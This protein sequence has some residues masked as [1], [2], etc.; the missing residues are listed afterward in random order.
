QGYCKTCIPLHDKCYRWIG[1]G[2]PELY[3]AS[4]CWASAR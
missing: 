4:S 2:S 3:D 1:T